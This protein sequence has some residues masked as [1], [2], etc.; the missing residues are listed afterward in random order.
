MVRYIN[1]ICSHLAIRYMMFDAREKLLRQFLFRQ[2][3]FGGPFG[4]WFGPGFGGFGPGGFG[5]SRF[6]RGDLKLVILDLLSEKPRHGYDII[7]ALEKKFHGFYSP[8]PG[9][10]YPILQMLEDQDFVKSDQQNGKKVYTITEEGKKFLQDHAEEIATMQERVRPPWDAH[11]AFHMHELREEIG[12]TARL[13]FCNAA[14]GELKDPKKRKQLHE[15][16]ANFRNE[17]EKIFAI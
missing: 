1:L 3:G 12:K 17:L 7:Q 9:S 13:I 5:G 10:V 16:F 15:A 4:R 11:G 14:Q 8:S 2:P 6:E